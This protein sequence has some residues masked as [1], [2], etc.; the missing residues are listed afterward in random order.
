MKKARP[1]MEQGVREAE[2]GLQAAREAAA[3]LTERKAADAEA[4]IK[5]AQALPYPRREDALAQVSQLKA[6]KKA[7]EEGLAR[8]RDAL[9]GAGQAV[10]AAQQE[11]QALT[12]Q[13]AGSAPADAQGLA[14]EKARAQEEQRALDEA[15][16]R[17]TLRVRDNAEALEGVR[18]LAGEMDD[19]Q[20]RCR[21]M[22]ALSDTAN[23]DLAGKEKIKLETYVQAAY[24]DRIIRRAN[25]RLVQMSSGQFELVRRGAG[26]KQSQTGLDLGVLDHHN[27]TERDVRT[28]S[29]GESFLA[30]LS[31]ALGLSDE[32]QGYAGGVRLD[33]MFI[34]EGFG[35]LDSET[36]ALAMRALEG[37][38]QG[39]LIG[40]ISHVGDLKDR[41]SRQIV[42]RKDRSG[43]SAAQVVV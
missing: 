33:A 27:G 13:L 9:S 38:S 32:I 14:Q 26:G 35:S 42:V 28:L 21:W 18:R 6:K 22:K 37:V 17:L 23:G 34:D 2:T 16:Q 4:C 10:A 8:L 12:A 24:F 15:R 43:A 3:A 19:T 40:I 20:E 41:I 39:T 29:G 11:I 36:L 30:S 5:L 7:F 31:L 1:Q 25:Q